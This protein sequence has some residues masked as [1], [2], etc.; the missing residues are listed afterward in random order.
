MR[1][2]VEERG[3]AAEIETQ[4]RSSAGSLVMLLQYKEWADRIAFEA[5]MSVPEEEAM[6]TRLTTFKNMV[7]TLN[8]VYVID[9][10]FRHHLAGREHGYTMRNTIDTPSIG[11]LWLSVQE[12]DRWY[13]DQVKT[14]TDDDLRTIVEFEFVGGGKGSMTKEEIILHIVNHTTYHRGSVG[15][16]L[17]QV[18]YN[19]PA[20]DLPVFIHDHYRPA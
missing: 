9:D 17:K 15:D 11:E 18:P 10:I 20:N 14:W 5:V 2:V 12:M 1:Q 4:S 8:H 7:H 13:I 6:K 3:I 19:W 16:M